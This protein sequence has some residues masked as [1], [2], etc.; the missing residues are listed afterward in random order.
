[1]IWVVMANTNFCRIYS[2]DKNHATLSLINEINHPE[3]RLKTSDTLT[4]ERP[5]HYHAG[6]SA[7]VA[8]SPHM[9]AKEVVID[10]FAREIAVKLDEGR[11]NNAYEK[12][13]IITPPQMN[14]LLSQHLNK[15][16]KQMVINTIQK[17]VP[18]LN[19]PELI[20]FL[21]THAQYPD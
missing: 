10:N 5:W 15:H 3:F 18:H 9:D 6:E 20:E 7:R 12:L 4:T 19:E 21:K 8:Y 14:G 11:K 1:M 2:Y 16:I 13:I 17:D